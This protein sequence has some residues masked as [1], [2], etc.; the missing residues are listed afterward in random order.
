M[1]ILNC[2]NSLNM[3]QYGQNLLDGPEF[4]SH[5]IRAFGS[6]SVANILLRKCTTKGKY[7]NI[8]L[9]LIYGLSTTAFLAVS[10][11]SRICLPPLSSLEPVSGALLA[12]GPISA[13]SPFSR[14]PPGGHSLIGAKTP[15]LPCPLLFVTP[16]TTVSTHQAAK[17]YN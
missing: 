8:Q 9:D 5:N 7:E 14:H 16:F 17:K 12:A 1:S 2:N 11:F 3:H 6:F 4:M 10:D 13:S 15:V